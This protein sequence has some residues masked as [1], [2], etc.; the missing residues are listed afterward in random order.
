MFPFAG[1]WRDAAL[2]AVGSPQLCRAGWSLFSSTQQQLLPLSPVPHSPSLRIPVNSHSSP[3][4]GLR[5]AV[6]GSVGALALSGWG[7]FLGS[8]SAEEVWGTKLRFWPLSS[9]ALLA[10]AA[11]KEA[12]GVWIMGSPAELQAGAE[13]ASTCTAR[14]ALVPRQAPARAFAAAGALQVS[15]KSHVCHRRVLFSL[16]LRVLCPCCSGIA[17]NV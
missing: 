15:S 11:L 9:T 5:G 1:G 17:I 7:R 8:V 12:V 14:K 6:M 3:L 10:S 2:P 16:C 13:L 4:L